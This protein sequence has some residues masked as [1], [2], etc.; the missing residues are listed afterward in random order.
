M[1]SWFSFVGCFEFEHISCGMGVW[2]YDILAFLEHVALFGSTVW[3][4]VLAKL[5]NESG[6]VDIFMYSTRQSVL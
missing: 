3:S 5:Y 2:G 4:C 6:G 1:A